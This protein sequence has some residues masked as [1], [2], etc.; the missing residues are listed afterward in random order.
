MLP[1]LQPQGN[2]LW[3]AYFGELSFFYFRAS[4][5]QKTARDSVAPFDLQALFDEHPT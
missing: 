2:D 3:T 1:E 5:S 4:S